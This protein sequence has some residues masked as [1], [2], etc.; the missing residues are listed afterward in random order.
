MRLEVEKDR[1]RLSLR[2]APRS[3]P[4]IVRVEHAA[5][6]FGGTRPWFCCPRCDSRRLLLYA[7]S[8]GLFGCRRCLKLV[9]SS[10]DEGKMHRLLR[11]QERLHSK[12][13]SPY[14]MGR[15]KGMHWA[16]F[17]RICEDLNSVLR[18]QQ[19]LRAES[20]R[21]F[22]DKHGWPHGSQARAMALSQW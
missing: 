9:F 2:D 13:G 4:T 1:L 20:A 19:H 11:R 10:Q 14:R 15:L 21:R 7:D 18:K 8:D 12:L 17:R 22:L 3:A 6:P 5:C 16:T